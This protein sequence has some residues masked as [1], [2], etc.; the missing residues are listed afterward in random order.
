MEYSVLVELWSRL[1]VFLWR[2]WRAST[3]LTPQEACPQ[4]I[5]TVGKAKVSEFKPLYR[6]LL[7]SEVSGQ[8]RSGKPYSASDWDCICRTSLWSADCFSGESWFGFESCQSSTGF[9]KGPPAFLE[10]VS[11]A[12]LSHTPSLVSDQGLTLKPGGW[13]QVNQDSLHVWIWS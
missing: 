6:S 2:S 5:L 7:L 9:P 10:D 12:F 1:F 13:H 8:L 4:N 3:I 11:E